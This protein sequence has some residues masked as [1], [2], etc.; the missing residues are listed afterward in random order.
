MS[1]VSV[2][3][4]WL[5]SGHFYIV[6]VGRSFWFKI[7]GLGGAHGLRF[8]WNEEIA[9]FNVRRVVVRMHNTCKRCYVLFGISEKIAVVPDVTLLPQLLTSIHRF[10][11]K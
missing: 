10:G 5:T 8:S 9:L 2:F 7:K 4:P 6:E 11:M 3:V 1:A